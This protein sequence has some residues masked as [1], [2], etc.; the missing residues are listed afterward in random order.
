MGAR[1]GVSGTHTRLPAYCSAVPYPTSINY[2][3][4]LLLKVL[5]GQRYRMS[6]LALMRAAALEFQ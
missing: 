6:V 2:T 3:I 5:T 4:I 1:T